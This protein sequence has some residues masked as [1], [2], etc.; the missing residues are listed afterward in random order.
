MAEWT[1]EPNVGSVWTV[2]CESQRPRSTEKRKSEFGEAQCF[3]LDQIPGAVADCSEKLCRRN[4]C[5][6]AFNL[7]L[8]RCVCVGDDEGERA[9]DV[10]SM[11]HQ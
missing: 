11:N 2:I 9:K 4:V 8:A 10:W 3:I 5:I 7:F 1:S 6:G